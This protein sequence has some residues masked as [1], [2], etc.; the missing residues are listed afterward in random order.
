MTAHRLGSATIEVSN[1]SSAYNVQI[2][3]ENELDSSAFVSFNPPQ[4]E[5]IT[6]EDAN[7]ETYTEFRFRVYYYAHNSKG[8]LTDTWIDISLE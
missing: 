5:T 6:R 7:G 4:I 2:T 8:Y 3:V 1:E